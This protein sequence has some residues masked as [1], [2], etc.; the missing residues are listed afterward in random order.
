[1]YLGI[2]DYVKSDPS[3]FITKDHHTAESSLLSLMYTQRC[4]SNN[5]PKIHK[6]TSRITHNTLFS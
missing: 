3:G 2:V 6:Q 5:V 1:M 4:A